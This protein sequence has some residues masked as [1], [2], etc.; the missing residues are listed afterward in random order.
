[1]LHRQKLYWGEDV[2]EFNPNRFLPENSKD[3]HSHCFIPFGAGPRSCLGQKYAYLSIKAS[4]V[5][6]LLAYK[7]ETSLKLKDLEFRMDIVCTITGGHLVQI[8]KR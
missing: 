4:I 5:R 7:F 6:L 8:K 3:R 1:M 2:E